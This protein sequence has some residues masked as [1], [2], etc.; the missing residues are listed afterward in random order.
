MMKRKKAPNPYCPECNRD[1]RLGGHSPSC[2]QVGKCIQKGCG[3]PVM[4]PGC[5][6]CGPCQRKA[7]REEDYQ[8]SRDVVQKKLR[9]LERQF[10][11][12]PI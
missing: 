9:G 3:K 1:L 4:V 5:Q 11:T 7:I 10:D 2:G 8:M 12:E 6:R